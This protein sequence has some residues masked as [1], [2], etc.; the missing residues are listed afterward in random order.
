MTI[1]HVSPAPGSL[2]RIASQTIATYPAVAFFD[3]CALD[4]GGRAATPDAYQR[5]CPRVARRIGNA[6][7]FVTILATLTFVA[8]LSLRVLYP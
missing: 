8:L 2:V 5:F 3:T 1:H 4:L 6:V 7:A